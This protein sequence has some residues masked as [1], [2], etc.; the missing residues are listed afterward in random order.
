MSQPL[1]SIDYASH[2]AYGGMFKP[3]MALRASALDMLQPL[4]DEMTRVETDRVQR[5]G[6]R[7]GYRSREGEE[8]VAKG[9]TQLRLPPELFDPVHAKA[10][11]VL[12]TI[13]ERIRQAR[14]AGKPIRFKTVNEPLNPE[15]HG[16]LWK[17]VNRFLL[18]MGI[19]DMVAAFYDAPSARINSLALFANP[20]NQEWAASIFRDVDAPPPSTAGFHID[21]NGKCYIKGILYLNDVGPG[22]GPTG[23]VLE[24]HRWGQEGMD[25]IYRRAFDRS[26]LLARAA[27]ERRLFMSLPSEM[28]VKAEFG[29]DMIPGSAEADA[30][31]ARE[32]TAVGPRGLLSLFDPEAIHRGGNVR[33]GERCVV[34][35]TLTA[36]Y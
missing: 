18:E 17:A 4:V 24:S 21:S 6:Y 10:Q 22:Q 36:Q 31:V 28:Q 14:E 26:K 32:V 13:R 20:A 16:S 34:Q 29:G 11:P 9:L 3:D 33:E 15:A 12:A 2:P 1:P 5:F 35:L 27:D 30:L 7:Y 19:L 8:L 25:R 23:V